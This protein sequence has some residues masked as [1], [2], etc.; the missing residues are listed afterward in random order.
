VAGSEYIGNEF[1]VSDQV[2]STDGFYMSN[3][4]TKLYTCGGNNVYQYILS[5]AWDLSTASYD[6]NFTASQDPTGGIF[7]KPDG[8]KF[9]F[10]N[11]SSDRVYQYSL[12]TPWDITTAS[13]DSVEFLTNPPENT[14]R[15]I[16][17]SPDGLNMFV[18]GASVLYRYTLSTAWLMSSATQVSSLTI[19]IGDQR[20]AFT[21]FF[22]PDGTN[23]YIP[24]S[25]GVSLYRWTLPSAWDITTATYTGEFFDLSH[26]ISG[27][28]SVYITPDGDGFYVL[29]TASIGS[30]VSVYQYN[31]SGTISV[32]FPAECEIPSTL[33]PPLI[34]EKAAYTFVTTDSGVSYQLTA[35]EVNL[36]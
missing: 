18:N 8:T 2:F 34:G 5:T 6:T 24:G 30:G 7:F 23:L 11:F 29:A 21:V 3:D 17:F 10:T 9:Y 13:Y 14:P 36:T 35:S 25:T 4:G 32:V 28:N 26:N 12:G 1:Y 15:G 19:P 16:F 22:S 33:E 31:M 20:N 27:L